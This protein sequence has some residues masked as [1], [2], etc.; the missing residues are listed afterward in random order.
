MT[1]TNLG[2]STSVPSGAIPFITPPPAAATSP[3]YLRAFSVDEYHRLADLEILRSDERVELLEGIIAVMS[4]IG[5]RHS[6]TVELIYRL[7]LKL[8]PIGWDV[9]MQRD[10]L[11]SHSVPQPDL[12]VLRGC[13]KDYFDHKPQAADSGLLIEVAEST[14]DKDRELKQRLYAAAGIPEYWIVNLL[15]RK[16]EVYRRPV[17]ASGEQPARYETVETLGPEAVANVVLDG[18]QVGSINVRD[19]LP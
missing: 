14:L 10:L 7:F 6:T 4:P 8:L 11:L 1:Q 19:I 17:A 12:C 9:S 3:L 15:E 13:L 18:V 16:L 5:P 2:M